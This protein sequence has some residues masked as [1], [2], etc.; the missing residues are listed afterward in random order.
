MIRTHVS[1]ERERSITG[2]LARAC[3]WSGS[4]YAAKRPVAPPSLPV[5]FPQVALSQNKGIGKKEPARKPALR[6]FFSV[7]PNWS[8]SV[9]HSHL[10]RATDPIFGPP[11]R[12][13]LR[14]LAN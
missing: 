14:R 5:S 12:A 6:A 4:G 11:G 2:R 13:V 3:A 7:E 9:V 10:I 8:S 1:D